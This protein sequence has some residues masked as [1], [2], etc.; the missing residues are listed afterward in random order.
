MCCTLN[1]LKVWKS[2][3]QKDGDG[4]YLRGA[5][6]KIISFKHVIKSMKTR[7]FFF[8]PADIPE[9]DSVYTYILLY[10]TVYLTHLDSKYIL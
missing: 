3:I 9:V 10:T 5:T 8:S 6:L 4:C 2:T 7:F 1:N